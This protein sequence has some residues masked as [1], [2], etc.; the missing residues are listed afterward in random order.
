MRLATRDDDRVSFALAGEVDIDTAGVIRDRIIELLQQPAK[1][2]TVVMNMAAVS[3]LDS[4]G[5]GVLVGATKRLRAVGGDLVIAAPSQRV[6]MVIAIAKLEPFL[7]I[8]A[9]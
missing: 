2:R 6:A 4:T 7:S 9:A 1:P 3:F 8:E 5:V